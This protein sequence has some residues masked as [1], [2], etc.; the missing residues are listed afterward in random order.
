V[1]LE[2]QITLVIMPER[3]CIEL[4]CSDLPEVVLQAINAVVAHEAAGKQEE[5]S[6]WEEERAV[7]KYAENLEQLPANGKVFDGYR[8]GISKREV[9][10]RNSARLTPIGFLRIRS[11]LQTLRSGSA[12]SLAP[13]RTCG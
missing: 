8:N 3:T 2:K 12:M 7:S 11:S 13:R 6:V 4:P 5:V 10:S 1:Q 9:S